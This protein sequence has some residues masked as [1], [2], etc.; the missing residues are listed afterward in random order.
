MHRCDVSLTILRTSVG[1]FVR[2]FV[3]RPLL[4]TVDNSVQQCTVYF[5]SQILRATGKPYHPK[6]FTCVVCKQCLDGVPFTVRP[7]YSLTR[8]GLSTTPIPS[9]SNSHTN[10]M[11]I[12]PVLL[13]WKLKAL[14]TSF[15]TFFRWMRATTF[16]ASMIFTRTTLYHDHF[17]RF[18]GRSSF[19]LSTKKI[20]QTKDS[21]TSS[22]LEIYLYFTYNT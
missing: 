7:F 4:T 16:T 9:Q 20:D 3:Y 14:S 1:I 22:E 15:L 2:L 5:F 8:I 17:L 10:T 18:P 6:C 13:F 11:L 12:N 19:A 21:F